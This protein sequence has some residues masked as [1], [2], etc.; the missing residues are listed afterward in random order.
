MSLE[1]PWMINTQ[2]SQFWFVLGR[3][4]SISERQRKS[5]EIKCPSQEHT[6]KP[7]CKPV[8]ADMEGILLIR[9][10]WEVV[11]NLLFLEPP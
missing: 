5:T 7:G 9:P 8:S 1:H 4:G 6:A 10:R 11:G 3:E 2:W